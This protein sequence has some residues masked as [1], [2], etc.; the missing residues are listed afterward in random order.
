MDTIHFPSRT[1]FPT[2]PLCWPDRMIT[3]SP[4][5]DGLTGVVLP[6]YSG[7][8]SSVPSESLRSTKPGYPRCGSFP[9][10]STT[11]RRTIGPPRIW[12]QIDST[13]L[14]TTPGLKTLASSIQYPGGGS[15]SELGGCAVSNVTGSGSR[16][17]GSAWL[18]MSKSSVTGGSEG[19]TGDTVLCWFT[20]PFSSSEGSAIESDPGA[21]TSGTVGIGLGIETVG[22][23]STGLSTCSFFF[24]I[25]KSLKEVL[26]F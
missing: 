19:C 21:A 20:G 15:G 4:S 7:Y 22:D 13:R 8:V 25:K 23:E 18:T 9:M 11:P 5:S 16:T 1:T 3:T 10:E 26:T 17:G 2:F 14:T 12:S 6:P 24:L